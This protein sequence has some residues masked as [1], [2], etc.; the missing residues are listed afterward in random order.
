MSKSIKH[1]KG[2]LDR[3]EQFTDLDRKTRW[4]APKS[5]L[6]RLANPALHPED[7]VEIV[8][9]AYASAHGGNLPSQIITAELLGI[10]RTWVSYSIKKLI[11]Q[12]RASFIHGELVL[13]NSEWKHPAA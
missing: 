1:I 2:L 13:T 9:A 3:Y 8:M 5:V 4:V 7:R 12:N 11:M 10:T 6:L